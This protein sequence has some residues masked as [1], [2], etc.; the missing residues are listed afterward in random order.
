MEDGGGI[1]GRWQTDFSCYFAAGDSAFYYYFLPISSTVALR[2]ASRLAS[3]APKAYQTI[4]IVGKRNPKKKRWR[5]RCPCNF[6]VSHPPPFV[7]VCVSPSKRVCVRAIA[8]TNARPVHLSWR[9]DGDGDR[10]GGGGIP[11]VPPTYRVRPGR[12]NS[13]RPPSLHRSLWRRCAPS[14][15]YQQPQQQQLWSC[16]SSCCCRCRLGRQVQAPGTFAAGPPNRRFGHVAR[17]V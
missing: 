10:D 17:R 11:P 16:A 13:P 2:R 12:R 5:L 1:G 7:R 3:V 8:H 4:N 9:Q 15:Q 14:F 6:V